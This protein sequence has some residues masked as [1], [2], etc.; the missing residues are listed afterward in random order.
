M[1]ETVSRRVIGLA[2]EV[3]RHLG[4]GL[5]E[6]IYHACLVSEMVSSGV[7]FEQE[8]EL[9]IVYKGVRLELNY[10]VDL[11]IE[12]SL[13]VEVKSVLTVLPVHRA[14]LLTYL[15]L[16]KIRAGLLLNFNSAVLKDGIVRMVNQTLHSVCGFTVAFFTTKTR[17]HKVSSFARFRHHRATTQCAGELAKLDRTYQH[18]VPTL[19]KIQR[20]TTPDYHLSCLFA[21]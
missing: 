7:R 18:E 5:L 17:R 2:I 4:P 20:I 3:H 9:P 15:R 1:D 8:V 13:V 6:S 19:Y 14:Q 16:T 11:I 10:R 21:F 12:R